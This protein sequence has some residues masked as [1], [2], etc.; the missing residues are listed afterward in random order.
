M[1]RNI[2]PLFNLE[3]PASEI[4]IRASAL[5]YVRKVSGF[6]NPSQA[7]QAAFDDAVDDLTAV[8]ERLLRTLLTSVAKR[9]RNV[10]AVK[11][12]DRARVRFGP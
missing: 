6:T 7:N 11:A 3:P 8:T 12:R 5:Q 1:C 2:R 10:E 9:D 4:E